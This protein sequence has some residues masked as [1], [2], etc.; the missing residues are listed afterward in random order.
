MTCLLTY[1]VFY[2]ITVVLLCPITVTLL[3]MQRWLRSV[4]LSLSFL[5]SFCTTLAFVVCIDRFD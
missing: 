5:F 3:L 1:A 4:F 2:N